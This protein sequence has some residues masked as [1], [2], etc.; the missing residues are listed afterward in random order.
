MN[1]K[2]LNFLFSI[3]ENPESIGRY[4][5]KIGISYQHLHIVT[6]A[7]I[8]DGIIIRDKSH[9]PFNLSL[10]PRGKE[11]VLKLREVKKIIDRK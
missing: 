7:L 8:K 9:Y 2:Y 11:L 3:D 4:S 1:K 10:T 5:K 6:R